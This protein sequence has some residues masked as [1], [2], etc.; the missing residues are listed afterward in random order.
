MQNKPALLV[1]RDMIAGVRERVDS[2]GQVLRPLNE[3]DVRRKLRTLVDGGA[4]AL[5]VSLL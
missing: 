3:D 4:R 2:F 5:A 1:I